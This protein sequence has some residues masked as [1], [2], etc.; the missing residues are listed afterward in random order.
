MRI[1]SSA[2]L[3]ILTYGRRIAAMTLAANTHTSA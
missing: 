1:R 2:A 3:G